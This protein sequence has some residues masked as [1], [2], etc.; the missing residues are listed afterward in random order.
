MG[1]LALFRESL[2]AAADWGVDHTKDCTCRLF[3]ACPNIQAPV[4]LD[5]TT[6]R[7]KRMLENTA[8]PDEGQVGG[9]LCTEAAI[10][11]RGSLRLKTC[12]VAVPAHPGRPLGQA[13]LEMDIRARAHDMGS[14]WALGAEMT[15]LAM[16]ESS[17]GVQ[18]MTVGAGTTGM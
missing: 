15:A 6:A 5:T 10:Q 3:Q 18:D 7:G 12:K 9:H 16:A 13:E 8:V 1:S 2:L 14:S 11:D 4:D 17:E